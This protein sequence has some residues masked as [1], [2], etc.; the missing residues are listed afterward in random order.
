M[1]LDDFVE[2]KGHSK[3]IK[4]YTS[5]GYD[6][7]VGTNLLVKTSDL[8]KGSSVL[9]NCKCDNCSDTKKLEFKEYY[10]RTDGI[11]SKYYCSKC[12]GLKIKETCI[13][14][15]GVDNPMKVESIK[16]SMIN[17]IIDKYGVNHYSKTSEYKT[18]YKNTCTKRYGVDN[19]SKSKDIKK[20]ISNIKFREYNSIEKYSKSLP[21]DYKITEYS[22]QRTFKIHHSSCGKDFD[23][24]CVTLSDRLRNSNI[25]CTNCNPIDTRSSGR[26]IELKMFIKELG[27]EVIENSYDIIKPLSIDIYLPELKIGF[28]FNG[29]Y[30]HSEIH[31]DRNYHI[32][33]TNRCSEIGIDLIHIWE[34][35]WL[36]KG[37]I[38]KSM[39][40]NRLNINKNTIYARNCKISEVTDIKLVKDFL[41]KNH[42]QGYSNSNI[43]IGLFYNNE[44][45]SIMIFGKK[46]KEMEL[47]R[48]C[49]KTGYNVIGGA[50]RLFK[51]FT[52][53]YNFN[54]IISY[55]D[56]SFFNG[57]LYEKLGF[58]LEHITKPSF[59]WVIGDVRKHRF[60]FTKKRISNPSNM[61]KSESDI[62]LSNGYYRIWNCGL[63]KWKFINEG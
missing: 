39:I 12:K 9:I 44:L 42:I 61:D 18:K 34:D 53:E 41:N 62:M 35:D 6:I 37:D 43:K 28:E 31:K 59:H 40:L 38:V 24:F 22:H 36:Y 27:L 19:A 32:D 51:Y 2:I 5:K 10:N 3:N 48:F 47:V 63:K 60:N 13:E 21:I 57:G 14:R 54:E 49:S 8:S 46:R 56:I 15:Y 16:T 30:W 52:K 50:S 1:I 58:K 26:E 11:N 55:S 17:N 33:K 4:Y 7:K 23:I 29:L 20:K 25:V 45:V